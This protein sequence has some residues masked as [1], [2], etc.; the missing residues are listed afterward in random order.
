MTAFTAYTILDGSSTSQTVQFFTTPG[1][2][3]SAL[4]MPVVIAVDQSAFP[5]SQSGTWNVGLSAGSNAIGS[6][7]NTTFSATQSGTWSVGL[8]AGSNAIGSITNTGFQASGPVADGATA[9]GNPVRVG[10]IYNSSPPTYTTGQIGSLQLDASGNVK[11]NLAAGATIASPLPVGIAATYF[12][13][14]TNNSS[15]AQLAAGATFTGVIETT[16][17]EPTASILVV[18]DQ[19]ILLTINQFI[20]AGGTKLAGSTSFT[21]PAGAG[22]FARSFAINANYFQITAK[23]TGLSTT[24]TFTVDV[25]YG[26]MPSATLLLNDPVAINEVA[27]TALSSALPLGGGIQPAVPVRPL[28]PQR[29]KADFN[30]TYASG[31]NPALWTTVV[32]GSGQTI[33]QAAG[34]LALAAGT[35]ANSDTIIRSLTSFTNAVALKWQA[36]LSQRIAN[37]NFYVELVDVIGDGLAITINSATSV[38]VT[39][40]STTLP[41]GST[42]SSANVGQ[43]MYLANFTG[44]AAQITGRYAIASVSGTAV[45]FTVAGFPATGSGTCSVFGWNYHQITYSGT[46]A[47]N[48][49]FDSQRRGYASGTTTATIN[50]T[51]SPGHYGIVVSEDDSVAFLDQLVASNATLQT[52][53]RATRVVNVPA[54]DIPL[55]LQIRSSNGSTAP[56]TTTTLNMTVVSVDAYTPQTVGVSTI[57][58]Q[59]QQ[60]ATPVSV[61]GGTLPTVTTVA[62][63]TSLSQIAASV[64]QMNISNGSTNKQLGVSMGTAITQTDVSAAAFAGAGR[65]QGT[66]ISSAAGGGCVISAEVSI[67]ALTLGTASA[68]YFTLQESTGGTNFSDIWVSDPITTTGIIRVPAIYVA[69]RRRWSAFSVGGTSTTVTVTVTTLELPPGGNAFIRQMRDAYAAT[70]PFALYYNQAALTASNFV[71]S[72]ISTATTPF[73]LEGTKVW[74]AFML[75]AG[76]PTVTTQPVVSVQGSMDGTNWVT[77]SGS[78]MT[79]AGNGLYSVT[80]NG[81]SFKFGRLI[82]TTAAAFSSGSYTITSIGINAVN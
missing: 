74:T 50:T 24:T 61:A 37:N 31:V 69:G 51:A 80:V 64:P 19:P 62:T 2:T 72:T 16:F 77:I 46:T 11:V 10:G 43:Y 9:T 22:Q 30:G 78:T 60:G 41:D 25:S 34:V 36:T 33:S 48:A 39:F 59:S 6:I 20:D 23:N 29:F 38:T 56:A 52:T 70:N 21:V 4:S 28:A 55:Y 18:S 14:S 82:V 40:P 71:L 27:G 65:V 49:L 13:E 35:T 58:P 26:T 17:N 81:V 73:N 44:T 3:T 53:V 79:A 15:T 7:T 12:T 75:L 57:K 5:V 68:V 1:Q 76:G 67:S 32:T 66:V 45:T 54:Y 42:L 47:T 63:V 8:A